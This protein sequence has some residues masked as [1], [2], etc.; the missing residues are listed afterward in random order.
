MNWKHFL[1]PKWKKIVLFIL[2]YVFIPY[3]L[4]WWELPSEAGT[5]GLKDLLSHFIG[6]LALKN[7]IEISKYVI[8]KYGLGGDGSLFFIP[9][10]IWL[11]VVYLLSCWIISWKQKKNGLK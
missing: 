3:P 5:L 8:S 6:P 7:D 10:F 11:I 4:G 2:L 1:K 9:P